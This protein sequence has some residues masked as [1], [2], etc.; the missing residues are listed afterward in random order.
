MISEGV[1]LSHA[2]SPDSFNKSVIAPFHLKISLAIVINLT[3][4]KLAGLIVSLDVLVTALYGLLT[5]GSWSSNCF[6]FSVVSG[7]GTIL[8][9][10]LG[11]AL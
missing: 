2:L 7:L 4:V 8:Y 6:K 1:F 9:Y 10:L 11:N 5:L 3:L